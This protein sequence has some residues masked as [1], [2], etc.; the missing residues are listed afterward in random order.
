M[1]IRD[2]DGS[3]IA[4]AWLTTPVRYVKTEALIGRPAA[5]HPQTPLVIDG[6]DLAVWINVPDELLSICIGRIFQVKLYYGQAQ[7]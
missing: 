7:V 6:D 4:A 1:T 5:E 2:N 3:F